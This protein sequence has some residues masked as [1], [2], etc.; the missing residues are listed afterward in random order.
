MGPA[1]WSLNTFCGLCPGRSSPQ[2]L[3][4]IENVQDT[5]Q[6]P[7]GCRNLLHGRL[8]STV[9]SPQ[10]TYYKLKRLLRL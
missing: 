2:V 8:C 10:K 5:A 4:T 9:K 6:I 1:V 3:G 7:L